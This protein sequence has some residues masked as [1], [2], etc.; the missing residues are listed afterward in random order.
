MTD[1]FGSS[2]F[3]KKNNGMYDFRIYIL[4]RKRENGGMDNKGAY[5]KKRKKGKI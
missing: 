1:R 5:K 4:L 3:K 2:S